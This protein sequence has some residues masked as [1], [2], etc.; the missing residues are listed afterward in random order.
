MRKRFKN[1]SRWGENRYEV[2][3]DM[4]VY[5]MFEQLGWMTAPLTAIT[6]P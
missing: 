4:N 6:T 1:W 2:T 3:G 5:E